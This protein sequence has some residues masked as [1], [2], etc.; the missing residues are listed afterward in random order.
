MQDTNLLNRRILPV[1]FFT[2][3]ALISNDK[4]PTQHAISGL[5]FA[6]IKEQVCV[7]DINFSEDGKNLSF[8]QYLPNLNTV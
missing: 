5:Y 2:N 4:K 7:N 6:D 3:P 8:L 1:L